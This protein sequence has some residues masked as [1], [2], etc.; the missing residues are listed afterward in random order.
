MLIA[1]FHDHRPILTFLTILSTSFV[2]MWLTIIG[3]RRDRHDHFRSSPSSP[4]TPYWPPSSITV[5][6]EEP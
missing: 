1:R 6:Y 3:V 5:D 2:E 4:P